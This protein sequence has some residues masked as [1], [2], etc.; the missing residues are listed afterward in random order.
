M[1]RHDSFILVIFGASGDLTKR[2]LIPALF[3]LYKQNLLTE[4]FAI[5]GVSRSDLSDTAFRERMSEG[6]KLYSEK[7]PE[8]KMLSSFCKNIHYQSLDAGNSPDYARL[9]TRLFQIDTELKTRGNYIYY[10]STSPNLFPI[11]TESLG[12]EDL[13]KE[14]NGSGWKRIVI[15]KPFG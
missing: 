1:E 14:G 10:L 8:E 6:I 11:I 2:K 15:E 3:A 9:R 7:Q 13:N 12:N 4:Q 5:L